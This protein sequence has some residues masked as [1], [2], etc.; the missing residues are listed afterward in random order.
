MSLPTT[1]TTIETKTGKWQSTHHG[2]FQSEDQSSS[3]PPK[4]NKKLKENRAKKKKKSNMVEIGLV[5]NA[6][7]TAGQ[8]VFVDLHI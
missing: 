6:G 8:F 7:E 4:N 2:E 5:V 1:T 3:F